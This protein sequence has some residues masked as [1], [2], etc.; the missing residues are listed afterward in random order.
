M[1]QVT[2]TSLLSLIFISY[3]KLKFIWQLPNVVGPSVAP[4][5][6]SKGQQRGWSVENW[7]K[8]NY[9]FMEKSEIL[10]RCYWTILSYW[11]FCFTELDRYRYS[12]T[13]LW[14]TR[15]CI[16]RLHPTYTIELGVTFWWILAASG[17]SE[18]EFPLEYID[19]HFID[20]CCKQLLWF[21]FIHFMKLWLLEFGIG[22]VIRFGLSNF[23]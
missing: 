10:L 16:G 20:I 5:E 17:R 15:F 19:L 18:F 3:L 4:Q 2:P 9:S 14:N 11:N 13:C 12:E 23:E 21:F 6:D 1:E 22:L 7:E 8:I